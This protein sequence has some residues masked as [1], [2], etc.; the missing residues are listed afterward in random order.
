MDK[1]RRYLEQ[2]LAQEILLADRAYALA[3]TIGEHATSIKS[4]ARSFDELFGTLQAHAYSQAL[5]SIARLYDRP[6]D[7]NPTRCM[8]SML[9]LVEQSAQDLPPI[10][11][12]HTLLEEAKYMGLEDAQAAA[13][14]QMD[15]VGVILGI[16]SFLRDRLD[17]PD[18]TAAV[19]RLHGLRD[20]SLVHNED[21]H[22][23]GGPTWTS[24]LDLLE[25]AKHTVGLIGWA[26]FRTA[27]TINGRYLVTGDATRPALAVERLL[28][29][30]EVIPA[31]SLR[32][33][34]RSASQHGPAD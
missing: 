21:V 19:A 34:G 16:V 25:I 2:G 24:L 22:R 12:R 10:S 18:V 15:D 8:A 32:G 26:Y 11:D 13:L 29:R 23:V 33:P 7:R 3:H 6:S 14:D 17:T 9:D 4:R 20:K 1:L 31:R 5:L 28:V 30:L 27:W